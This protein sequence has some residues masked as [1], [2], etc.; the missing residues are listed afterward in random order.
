VRRGPAANPTAAASY[1]PFTDQ[2]DS[3]RASIT[4]AGTLEATY[5]YSAYGVLRDTTGALPSPTSTPAETPTPEPASS[6]W[7][8]GIT[9]PFTDAS[10]NLTLQGFKQRSTCVLPVTR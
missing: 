4:T 6:S 3:V 5:A 8:T 2:V 7:D 10:P 1:H 9:T